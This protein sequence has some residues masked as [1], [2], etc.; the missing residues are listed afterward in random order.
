MW[1]ARAYTIDSR[2]VGFTVTGRR[3]R[4]AATMMHTSG[5]GPQ[6]RER[7]PKTQRRCLGCDRMILTTCASRL[8]RHCLLRAADL[9]G[10]VDEMH[11]LGA[12]TQSE[13]GAGD[14]TL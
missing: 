3:G 7:R 5:P 6:V 9:R 10:G 8:C 13:R 1:R 12:L 2:D 14:P 11:L 4:D